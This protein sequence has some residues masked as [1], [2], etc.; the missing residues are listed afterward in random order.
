VRGIAGLWGR[1]P[2]INPTNFRFGT[3]K[4]LT[5]SFVVAVIISRRDWCCFGEIAYG[6]GAGP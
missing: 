3:V 2:H 1:A 5:L 6:N 4:F